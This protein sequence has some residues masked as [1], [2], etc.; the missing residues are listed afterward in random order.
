M[1]VRSHFERLNQLIFRGQ[2]SKIKNKTKFAA[3]CYPLT[4]LSSFLQNGDRGS[5][6]S[7]TLY[8]K[9]INLK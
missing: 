7:A 2:I 4:L 8:A 3:I 9:R 1:T 6:L 5:W